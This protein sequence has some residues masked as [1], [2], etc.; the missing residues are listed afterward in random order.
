LLLLLLFSL[1]LY[2]RI[3]AVLK[4]SHLEETMVEKDKQSAREKRADLQRQEQPLLPAP[5]FIKIEKNLASLGFFTP[6]SK[7]I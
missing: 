6:S 5:V 3:S 2:E 7:R 1:P 4:P